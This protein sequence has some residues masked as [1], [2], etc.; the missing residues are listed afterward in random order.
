MGERRLLELKAR[1]LDLREEAAWCVEHT[2]PVADVHQEDTY[3]RVARGRLKLRSVEGEETGTLLYYEREDRAAPK[4]SRVFLLPVANPAPLRRMLREALGI[5]VT[6][7]K[8]RQ[9]FRWGEVQI[10]LDDVD[11][12]GTFLELERFVESTRDVEKA[13]AEFVHLRDGL[14]VQEEDLIAGSYSDLLLEE[15]ADGRRA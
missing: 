12:L 2:N 9:I 10:H 4:R 11:G 5:L 15:A 3:F 14:G 7:R 8:H 1:R 13:Q 6:V